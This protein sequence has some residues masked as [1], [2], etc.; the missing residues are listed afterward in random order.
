[1]GFYSI[2]P[3]T[4]RLLHEPDPGYILKRDGSNAAAVLRNFS[5]HGPRVAGMRDK[6][7]QLLSTVVNGIRAV[8]EAPVGNKETLWFSQDIGLSGDAV[9]NAISMSDGTL[10]VL[11]LLLAVY[12]PAPTTVIGIEEPELTV[13]PGLLE[14][15]FDV[16]KDASNEKQVLVTTHSPDILDQKDLQTSQLRVVQWREGRT[17]IAPVSGPDRETIKQNLYTAGELLR[18][19]ELEPDNEVARINSQPSDLFGPPLL[20]GSRQE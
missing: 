13:H 10:R 6:L 15:I 12:Q 11:G 17:L 9:F 2:N 16:L 4:L 3:E 1:M 20:K 14:M 7:V 19:D 18:I 8:A 5:L